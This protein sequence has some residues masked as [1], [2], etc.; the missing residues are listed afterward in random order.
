MSANL[1]TLPMPRAALRPRRVP[2]E[3]Q[4]P[5]HDCLVKQASCFIYEFNFGIGLKTACVAAACSI[6]DECLNFNATLQDSSQ[7]CVDALNCKIT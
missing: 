6:F 4:P 3:R 1:L 2:F 5:V 7:A